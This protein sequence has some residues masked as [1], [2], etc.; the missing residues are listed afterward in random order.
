MHLFSSE[1]GFSLSPYDRS[2]T[3]IAV[4]V[5]KHIVCCGP[6]RIESSLVGYPSTGNLAV[7]PFSGGTPLSYRHK[8]F[9]TS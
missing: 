2:A 1:T 4:I 9:S 8:L 7:N 6:K 5:P 3:A